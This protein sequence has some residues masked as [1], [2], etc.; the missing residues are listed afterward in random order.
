[1]KLYQGL[2]LQELGILNPLVNEYLM[3]KSALERL[4][5]YKPEMASIQAAIDA[6]QS[7]SNRE[8]LVNALYNQYSDLDLSAQTQQN[9][10]ALKEENTYSVCAAHQL[11]LFTGPSYFIFKIL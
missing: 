8:V 7:F 3:G 6:K 4:Y 5:T 9:I 11:C 10:E 1:M 2:K